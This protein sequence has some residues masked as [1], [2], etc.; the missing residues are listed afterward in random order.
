MKNEMTEKERR[1]NRR[2]FCKTVGLDWAPPCWQRRGLK[3]RKPQSG[4]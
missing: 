3:E 1:Y 4:G 2:S